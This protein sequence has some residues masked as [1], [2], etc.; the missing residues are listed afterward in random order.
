MWDQKG[1][2]NAEENHETTSQKGM[3]SFQQNG[4]GRF[5]TQTSLWYS[6][7]AWLHDCV[8]IFQN[9]CYF[10]FSNAKVRC[11]IIKNVLSWWKIF[12]HDFDKIRHALKHEDFQFII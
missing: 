11:E 6:V 4:L 12:E 8:V 5:L 7:L 9:I 2:V 3:E 10:R 1:Q